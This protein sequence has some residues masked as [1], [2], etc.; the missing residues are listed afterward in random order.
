MHRKL[1][2]SVIWTALGASAVTLLFTCTTFKTCILRDGTPQKSAIEVPVLRSILSTYTDVFTL[3]PFRLDS[4]SLYRVYENAIEGDKRPFDR[5]VVCLSTIASLDHLH[6]LRELSEHWTG[7]VSVAVFFREDFDLQLM[8]TYV[9]VLRVCFPAIRENFSFHFMSPA[10][11]NDSGAKD[12]FAWEDVDKPLFCDSHRALLRAF[13]SITRRRG[14]P[15]LLF[16]QNHLR[17]VARDGCVSSPYFYATDVDVMPQYGLYDRL[18]AFLLR[19]PPCT[20]CLYVVP[21]F[22]GTEFVTHPRTKSA[23]LSRTGNRKDFRVYHA[24]AFSKNQRATNFNKW[25]KVPSK[26]DLFVAYEAVFEFGYECFYVGPHDVPKFR[27][28]FIGYGFTRNVQTL[29]AHLAGFRFL[30]LS[31]AFAIHRG[32]RNTTTNDSVRNAEKM[33]NYRVFL[34]FRKTLQQRYGKGREFS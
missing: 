19:Q 12:T 4:Q 5:A 15:R 21:A 7:P 11:R 22:E 8:V 34:S 3:P 13:L 25:R 18:S 2:K 31:D 1:R 6:W 27:E 17:N 28:I 30:V 9:H 10:D 23:L 16:P 33:H 24:V 32:M 14:W 29:E 20:K 26:S